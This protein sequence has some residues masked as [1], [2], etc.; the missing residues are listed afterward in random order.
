LIPAALLLLRRD[1]VRIH[2][3]QALKFQGWIAIAIVVLA[4]PL[5]IGIRAQSTVAVTVCAIVVG[6]ILPV[7]ELI[8]AVLSGVAAWRKGRA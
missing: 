7:V 4:I 3:L 2:A 6:L 1:F 5:A 8:R